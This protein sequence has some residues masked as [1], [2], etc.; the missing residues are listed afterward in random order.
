MDITKKDD[1][2]EKFEVEEV[3][4]KGTFISVMAIGVFII[5][6]WAAIY[7]LFITR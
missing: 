2:N 5:I 6:S 7:V 3:D 4:L 1:E